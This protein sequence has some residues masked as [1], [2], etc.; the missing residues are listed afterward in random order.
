M[1]ST[2]TRTR[3]LLSAAAVL[4]LASC[5]TPA[6]GPSAAPPPG[7]ATTELATAAPRLAL[8]YD[9][10]VQVLDATTLEVVG[11]VALGGFLRINPAGDGRHA[12]LSTPAGFQVL[13]VGS[14]AEPHGDHAHYYATAP[15]LLDLTYPAAVPGH[16][17]AHD[18]RTALFDDGTGHVVV[19]DAADVAAPDADV[20]EHST[21]SAHHGVAVELSDG[22]LVV[23]EGTAEA[24][25]G[26]RVLDARGEELTASDECPGV[27]G[28]TVAAHETV[29]LGCEDGVL[30][31]A[32]GTITKV[33]SPDAYGRI[34]N[35]RSTENSELVLGDYDPDP[36]G[37]PLTHVA[38]VDVHDGEMA[39]VDI[40]AEYTFRSLAVDDEHA[41]VLADDGR[42]HVI[43]PARTQV[44]RTI[45]VLDTWDV[46][47]DWQ[48]PRPALVVHDG[49]GYVTDPARQRVLAVDLDSGEIW[50][51]ASLSVTPNEIV[52]T[53]GDVASSDGGTHDAHDHDHGDD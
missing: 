39:L 19:L 6:D 43:D 52:L 37:G 44:A 34:G 12:L 25:T 47:A 53:S 33:D 31:Y 4:A 16:V 11:D 40:G 23:T 48:Q 22:T 9:G 15:S 17:V 36:D 18:G 21:A 10:G 46:P 20:R 30:L 51:E 35:L 45:D 2:T 3:V 32:D 27:H 49:T 28:E 1:I 24:R 8:T 14:W 50:N 38:L 7:A 42:I 5:S 29:V 13:D 26:I 41:F